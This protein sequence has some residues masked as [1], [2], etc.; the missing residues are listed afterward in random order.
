ML[1][2][3]YLSRNQ[4][5]ALIAECESYVSL[6]RSEGYGLTMAEAM[7]LGKP[8]IATGYSGNLDFM[9]S[10]NSLLVPYSMVKVGPG[11]FPYEP[12][13]FWADPDLETAAGYMKNLFMDSDFKVNL[14]RLAKLSVTKQYPLENATNF[15]INRSNVHFSKIYRLKKSLKKKLQKLIKAAIILTKLIKNPK[16]ALN[17]F[18]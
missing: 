14:G 13:S 12:E 10:E 3:N 7:A 9:S 4:L 8:V 6:H 5:H 17:L 18:K 15:I 11:S 1:I 2:E 16:K